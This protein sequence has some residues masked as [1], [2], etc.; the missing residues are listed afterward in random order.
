MIKETVICDVCGAGKNEANHWFMAFEDKGTVRLAAWGGLNRKRASTKH[1][2]GQ[3]CV[4]RY[5]DDFLARHSLGEVLPDPAEAV[6]D[7]PTDET[8]NQEMEPL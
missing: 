6:Q 8:G 2:C 1:L 4:H 7:T 5:V 3:S